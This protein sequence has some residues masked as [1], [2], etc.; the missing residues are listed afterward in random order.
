MSSQSL[1]LAQR[2]ALSYA[3]AASREDVLSLLLLDARLAA[4]AHV[5]GEVMIAQ[6]KLAWW[7]ERLGE[8]PARWPKGEPLLERL[9]QG[10]LAPAQLVPLVD[11]WEHLLV[12]E[13][14][15]DSVNAVVSARAEAWVLLCNEADAR[16]RVS[17]AGRH[18][19]L[20]DLALSFPE[21]REMINQSGQ[22]TGTGNSARLPRQLRTLAVLRAL[23]V[24]ANQ[25][26]SHDLLDGPAAVAVA[27]R[28]G[29]FGR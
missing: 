22:L 16:D 14:S 27:L 20:A 3:P 8:N 21:L 11:G 13:A 25:R 29:L 18:W 7:R 24:R 10:G 15:A 6:I 4:V 12:E 5:G 19:A 23:A 9:Q 2:L 28:V 17:E 26:S 1:P